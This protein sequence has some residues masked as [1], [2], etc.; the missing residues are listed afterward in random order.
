MDFNLESDKPSPRTSY[1][2]SLRPVLIISYL[3]ASLS[4]PA[5]SKERWLV[6]N[7]EGTN[8]DSI[9][10]NLD[11]ELGMQIALLSA[12]TERQSLGTLYNWNARRQ[13]HTMVSN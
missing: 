3:V 13:E 9:F 7:I 8:K 10:P 2:I 5:V 1:P 6:G 11:G 4:N 12:F